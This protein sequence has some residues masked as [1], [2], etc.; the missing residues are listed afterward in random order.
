MSDDSEDQS[1]VDEVVSGD[2]D[3][4]DDDNEEEREALEVDSDDADSDAVKPVGVARKHSETDKTV[5]SEFLTVKS[6]GVKVNIFDIKPWSRYF[7]DPNAPSY[8]EQEADENSSFFPAASGFSITHL[9]DA[10][11]DRVGKYIAPDTDAKFGNCL[12]LHEPDATTGKDAKQVMNVVGRQYNGVAVDVKKKS[13]VVF[14]Y[15]AEKRPFFMDGRAGRKHFAFATKDKAIMALIVEMNNRRTM[16]FTNAQG[17]IFTLNMPYVPDGMMT[18]LKKS[19]KELEAKGK[20][21]ADTK[22]EQQSGLKKKLTADA[23]DVKAPKSPLPKKT[24][25]AVL[26]KKTPSA[27]LPVDDGQA[28][29]ALDKALAATPAVDVAKKAPAVKR[30]AD[31]SDIVD[32]DERAAF[33][34]T[35]GKRQKMAF[36]TPLELG[37]I[38]QHFNYKVN[39]EGFKFPQALK[40]K[41]TWGDVMQDESALSTVVIMCDA[42]FTMA[43]HLLG[44]AAPPILPEKMHRI[45]YSS[46]M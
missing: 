44:V 31:V 24:V 35:V 41:K 25:K 15:D 40:G 22:H 18:G 11:L 5:H 14:R 34:C 37:A 13:L 8:D 2:E 16:Q 26:Q 28:N 36:D 1:I 27:P 7:D 30:K 38:L 45:D 42:L 4:S 17:A 21:V 12:I 23:V 29:T 33:F 43:P 46:L 39:A 9:T 3:S 32:A 10:H 6:D 19:L 20:P